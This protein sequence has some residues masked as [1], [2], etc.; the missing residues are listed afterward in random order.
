[1]QTDLGAA[2]EELKELR[3]E[4]ETLRAD[5]LEAETLHADLEARLLE[6]PPNPW[7]HPAFPTPLG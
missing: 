4:V 3:L 6:V 7:M 2:R 1:M 5:R